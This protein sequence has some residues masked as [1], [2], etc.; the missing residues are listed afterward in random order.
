MAD[1]GIRGKLREL[2]SFDDN[3]K[4]LKGFCSQLTNEQII[5]M[6]KA[7]PGIISILKDNLGKRFN[8]FKYDPGLEEYF[9]SQ[10]QGKDSQDSQPLAEQSNKND[11]SAKGSAQYDAS[12]IEEILKE[13]NDE[14]FKEYKEA[15]ESEAKR[16]EDEKAKRKE[17]E[18]IEQ[19][20]LAEQ[21]RVE[22]ENRKKE[23]EY[24]NWWNESLDE[25]E[26][27]HNP[28]GFAAYAV[29]EGLIDPKIEELR[30]ES[31]G[32]IVRDFTG[33][34]TRYGNLNKKE[35]IGAKG[36]ES[37]DIED[38]KNKADKQGKK[39][40]LKGILDKGKNKFKEFIKGSK[41]I[42]F[43]KDSYEKDPYLDV[44][45]MLRSRAVYLK[46]QEEA[47]KLKMQSEKGQSNNNGEKSFVEKK[48]R[49]VKG[50]IKQKQLNQKFQN[51]IKEQ[52]GKDIKPEISM[53]I[54]GVSYGAVYK[55]GETKDGQSEYMLVKGNLQR[56]QR[57][58]HINFVGNIDG[59]KNPDKEIE[60]KNFKNL[61]KYITY[62]EIKEALRKN[63]TPDGKFDI[64]KA[65]V[66]SKGNAVLENQKVNKD[67]EFNL[68][69][70][71]QKQGYDR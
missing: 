8:R 35:D 12:E 26:N 27:L 60:S 33:A 3:P 68:K 70:D 14:K 69:N 25:L 42:S 6:I 36:E 24:S 49:D 58:Q 56:P 9:K 22:E 4:A 11:S 63:R 34:P 5:E 50:Y 40:R 46:A 19:E 17:Q 41:I 61:L 13:Q 7:D 28:S 54:A 51:F 43:L 37:P 57:L 59:L 21:K 53:G 23:K 64:G 18:R 52:E 66:D 20:K 29:E 2:M 32:E 48:Y 38:S 15:K 45:A 47:R 44:E 39:F 1:D 31:W 67:I 62:P 65:T 30:K 71:K 55:I 16:I 10:E